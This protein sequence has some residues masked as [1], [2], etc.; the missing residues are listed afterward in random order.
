M[1]E[2]EHTPDNR[3]C[4]CEPEVR[5]GVIVHRTLAEVAYSMWMK[6]SQAIGGEDP[7]GDFKHWMKLARM[8]STKWD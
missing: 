4:W 8:R 1:D 5:G 6:T 2:P 3:S 7:G